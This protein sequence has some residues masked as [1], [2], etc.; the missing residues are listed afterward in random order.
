M[1]TKT[2]HVWV[3]PATTT[4]Q[5]LQKLNEKLKLNKNQKIPVSRMQLLQNNLE[6]A[7]D[8]PLSYYG[9]AN[10]A[11]LTLKTFKRTGDCPCAECTRL[12]QKVVLSI[13][14][15]SK[16]IEVEATLGDTVETVKEAIRKR[17]GIAVSK[18]RLTFAG[19]H[20]E[21]HKQLAFY[22][23]GGNDEESA[24]GSSPVVHLFVDNGSRSFK[25]RLR[26]LV[27]FGRNSRAAP[28]PVP[29]PPAP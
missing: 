29:A 25:D 2:V 21:N 6:M 5:M 3:T 24:E 9:I 4:L 17:E 11:R 7:E 27:S 16:S 20:L 1:V 26:S 23:F 14:W 12:K 18:Q 13:V 28:E 19:Q 15:L 10:G 8:R 22:K